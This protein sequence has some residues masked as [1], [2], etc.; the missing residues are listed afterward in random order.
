MKAE[1]KV[2]ASE[3]FMESMEELKRRG[4]IFDAMET[5]ASLQGVSC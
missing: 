1:L 3:S 5:S 4:V 2:L